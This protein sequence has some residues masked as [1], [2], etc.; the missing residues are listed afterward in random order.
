MTLHHAKQ[1]NL[2][3]VEIKKCCFVQNRN[4]YSPMCEN[5]ILYFISKCVKFKTANMIKIKFSYRIHSM[6][7][8]TSFQLF[9]HVYFHKK[10][11]SI[12]FKKQKYQDDS[13]I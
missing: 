9:S 8:P 5:S 1:K 2:Q 3:R 7:R 6:S 12:K 13:I 11:G 10:C 4:L